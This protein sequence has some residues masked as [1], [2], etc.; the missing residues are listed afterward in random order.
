M[1]DAEDA[2][3]ALRN[4]MNEDN[5]ET[6]VSLFGC[7]PW[8][9][10]ECI[11][12]YIVILYAKAFTESTGRTRLDG[13]INDIF[14]EDIDKHN[15]TIELRNEFYAHQGIEANRHQLFYLPNAPIPGKVRLNPD[16]QTT[17][18][19]MPTWIDI[20]IIEYCVAKV[21]EHLRVRIEG[22]CNTIEKELTA[23]QLEVLNSTPKDELMRRHWRENSE[24][25][26]SPFSK[27]KT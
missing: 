13:Q 20:E 23:E 2:L 7:V 22:L 16:G 21:K 24:N 12:S 9:I 17:R 1:D 19:L 27:R 11:L 14:G 5:K 18:I 26:I 6:L 10:S 4:S 15:S 25:R 8:K 3:K